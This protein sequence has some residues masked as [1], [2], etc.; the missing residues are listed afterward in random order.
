LGISE[1]PLAIEAVNPTTLT[2][3]QRGHLAE[4]VFMRKAA[5]LG[6]SVSKPWEE[7]ERYDVIVRVDSLLWRVQVKSVLRK[8]SLSHQDVGRKP[9][10]MYAILRQRN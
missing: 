8:A 9:S 10:Q 7:G 6:F 4:L 2:F 1:E 3:T 5:D